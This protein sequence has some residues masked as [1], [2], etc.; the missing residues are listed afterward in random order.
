MAKFPIVFGKRKFER[1]HIIY[2]K[3]QEEKVKDWMFK[4]GY[5]PVERRGVQ[6]ILLHQF[7]PLPKCK[8]PW[9]QRI[10]LHQFTPLPKCKNPWE[11][12]PGIVYLTVERPLKTQGR[13]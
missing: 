4:N 6:R 2:R 10:L 13:K 3:G 8:N 1:E 11:L 7:T 9:V 5:A 12:V